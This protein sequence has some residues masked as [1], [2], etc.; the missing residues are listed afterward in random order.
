MN[1]T[2]VF[3]N[4]TK[5]GFRIVLQK[6]IKIVV[7]FASTR[8]ILNSIYLGLNSRKRSVFHTLF[9]KIFVDTNDDASDGVWKV[10][11]A[12]KSILMP[13]NSS[14]M[15]LDWDSAVSIIGHDID[16][17]ETYEAIINSHSE[18][19]DI[20]VDIGAN[21]GTH[22]LLF[23]VHEISTLT[24]EPNSSCH[25]YFIEMCKL[26]N[27]KPKLEHMALG[28]E[29]GYVELAYPMNETWLGTTES[30]SMKRLGKVKTL[31][32][33]RV[34]Q[35]LLDSYLPSFRGKRVLIKIDTEGNELAVLLGATKIIRE[36]QPKII[37]ESWDGDERSKIFSFFDS[38]KYSIYSLPWAPYSDAHSLASEEYIESSATNFIA[39]PTAYRL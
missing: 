25:D 31:E 4:T 22:S 5:Y 24:F 8:R 18:K 3:S 21:Y 10:V 29:H 7:S 2:K 12:G 13:L 6:I 32:M 1:A 9:A 17:K 36:V 14:R 39:I 26:N 37:F 15:W 23:L 19:P 34:E 35:V 33:E 16:V 20:F 27:V 30:T 11:F 28:E 38:E